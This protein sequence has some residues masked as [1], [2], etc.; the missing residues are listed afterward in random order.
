[1]KK[2]RIAGLLLIAAAIAGAA[3]GCTAQAP[4][5]TVTVQAQPLPAVTVTPT[6]APGD[7]ATPIDSL[8]AWTICVAWRNHLEATG[9]PKTNKQTYAPGLVTESGGKFTVAYTGKFNEVKP[10]DYCVISG[11]LGNPVIANG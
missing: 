11:T 9:F 4:L 6:P 5:P 1:V 2:S 10:S 7:L 8:H 3:A